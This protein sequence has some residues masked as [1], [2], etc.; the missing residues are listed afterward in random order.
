MCTH[1]VNVCREGL[2]TAA[3]IVSPRVDGALERGEVAHACAIGEEQVACFEQMELRSEAKRA[4]GR[5]NDEFVNSILDQKHQQIKAEFLKRRAKR[6]AGLS[7]PGGG[8][9]VA[10]VNK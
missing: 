3:Q 8:S 6:N 5:K 9:K 1:R 2:T 7:M 4:A 10:T